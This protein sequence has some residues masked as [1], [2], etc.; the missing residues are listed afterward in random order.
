MPENPDDDV[1]ALLAPGHPAGT[2]A[3]H[4]PS[5]GAA[6]DVAD[7]MWT[8][9]RFQPLPGALV[10]APSPAATGAGGREL[11]LVAA[12]HTP[13]H[14][15]AAGVLEI[16][17]HR[18]GVLIRGEDGM[19]FHYGGLAPASL[20]LR[21]GDQVTPGMILGTVG[22]PAGSAGSAGGTRPCLRLRVL[23][24]KG[25]EVDAAGLLIGL[26]DPNELG[27]AAAGPGAEIDPDALDQEIMRGSGPPPWQVPRPQVRGAP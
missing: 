17:A 21:D 14:A 23:D 2:A 24:G 1:L 15:V 22:A 27:Y 20:T 16:S 18:D 6:A 9:C 19:E 10:I 7:S 11:V 12:V 3:S 26:A 4:A 8:G 13:V 25:A 5:S